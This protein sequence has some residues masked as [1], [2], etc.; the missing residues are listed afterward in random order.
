M[1]AER[2]GVEGLEEGL[3]AELDYIE[4]CDIGGRSAVGAGPLDKGGRDLSPHT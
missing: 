3:G 2:L 1:Q 4:S